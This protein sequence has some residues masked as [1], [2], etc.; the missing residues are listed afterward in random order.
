MLKESDFKVY[1]TISKRVF[2]IHSLI[3]S[4]S[5]PTILFF[6][7]SGK[8]ENV[9]QAA[10]NVIIQKFCLL[11]FELNVGSYSLLNAF[12]CPEIFKVS[13]LTKRQ[14]HKNYLELYKILYNDFYHSYLFPTINKYE[15]STTDFFYTIAWLEVTEEDF[16]KHRM[17]LPEFIE[18]A[19]SEIGRI[20]I[21]AILMEAEDYH[22]VLQTI[23]PLTPNYFINNWQKIDDSP[24]YKGPKILWANYTRSISNYKFH[25]RQ[26]ALA[27]E[28]DVLTD[29]LATNKKHFYFEQA[30]IKNNVKRLKY[31]DYQGLTWIKSVRT[32]RK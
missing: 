15:K 3:N 10:I 17:S 18:W 20:Y 11:S 27:I 28:W 9:N 19:D 23:N 13:N 1:Q 12:E 14:R 8:V 7:G 16:L 4:L 26:F 6:Q 5:E 32:L 2:E 30:L 22:K 21:D 29:P 25:I 31:E 24:I